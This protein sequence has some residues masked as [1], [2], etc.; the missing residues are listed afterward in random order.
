MPF[1]T[2]FSLGPFTVD[3]EGRLAPG[4]QEDFPSFSVV[5]RGVGGKS[6]RKRLSKTK[7]VPPQKSCATVLFTA[8]AKIVSHPRWAYLKPVRVHT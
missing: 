7:I 5:W 1:D 6:R 3:A 4:S 2:P 8:L